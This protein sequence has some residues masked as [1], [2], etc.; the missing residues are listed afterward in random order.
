MDKLG[1]DQILIPGMPVDAFIRTGEH[2]PFAYL[3]EPL[4]HYLSRALR[5]SS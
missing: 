1:P 3:T 4:V 5:E 2:T